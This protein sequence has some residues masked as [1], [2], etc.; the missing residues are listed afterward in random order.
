MASTTKSVSEGFTAALMAVISCIIASST[1]RRPAVSTITT[2]NEFLAGV[3]DGVFGDLYRVF[4]PLFGVDLHSGSARRAPSAGRW[5]RDG[6]RRL[7]PAVPGGLSLLLMNAASLPG[8]G[9]FTRALQTRDQDHGR[10]ALQPDV[11]GRAAHQF[12]PARRV[13]SWSSSVRASPP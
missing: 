8:E 9:G 2:L 11:C 4:V 7:P 10:V 13:R 12:R 3:F 6:I 1:A 5:P